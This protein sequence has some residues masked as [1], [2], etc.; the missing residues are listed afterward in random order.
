MGREPNDID[1]LFSTVIDGGYCIGCG[2][3]A[4]ARPDQIE[5]ALDAEGRL[6]AQRRKVDSDSDESNLSLPVLKVCPF[7]NQSTD[8]DELSRDLYG[9]TSRRDR[10][11]GRFVKC[12]AGHVAEGEYRQL[13]SSGGMGTWIL[14]EL[15]RLGV[16]DAVLHVKS[17]EASASDPRIVAYSESTTVEEV[18]QGAKSR[19]HPIEMSRIVDRVRGDERRFA[20]VGIPCFVKAM[21]LLQRHDADLREKITCCVGLFCGHLKS[22]AFAQSL[23]WQL[24]VPPS[25]LEEFD[26]RVKLPNRPAN[27]YGVRATGVVGEERVASEAAVADLFGAGWE[28][29]FF[30]YKACDYCDDV[31]AETADIAVGDAWIPEFVG[32]AQGANVIIVRDPT[33]VDIV[34]RACSEGRLSMQPIA[35]ERVAESQSA[36]FRHRRRGLAYRLK[37]TDER[38]EWRPKKRVAASR[39]AVPWDRRAIHAMRP[40]LSARSHEAFRR[41]REA[42]DF[43]MFEREMTPLIDR[44]RRLY[45]LTAWRKWPG[46]LKIVLR[47]LRRRVKGGSL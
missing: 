6:Q 28:L 43:A 7:S 31:V 35:P 4:A 3:C 9:Q 37:L 29:G 17:I 32:D 46:R 18:L 12:Y 5:M 30:K 11:L 38:G 45:Q 27:R 20:F 10:K 15:L 36:G 42:G 21:R 33:L 40:V 22:L 34:E 26:F 41:A 23:A 16:V 1:R 25:A 14:C 39:W 19:Y 2:A 47:R 24:G 8:E 13:G 44:Y